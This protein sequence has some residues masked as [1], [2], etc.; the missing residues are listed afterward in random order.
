MWGMVLSMVGLCAGC[1]AEVGYDGEADGPLGDVA[2]K[3]TIAY[4]ND[5]QSNPEDRVVTVYDVFRFNVESA[6]ATDVS[7]VTDDMK[8]TLCLRDLSTGANIKCVSG[9]NT[10]AQAGSRITFSPD[11]FVFEVG[12]NSYVH[13]G[14]V[15]TGTRFGIYFRLETLDGI[16][17]SASKLYEYQWDN[18][19]HEYKCQNRP[20]A[21]TMSANESIS[22]DSQSAALVAWRMHWL[23]T[24]IEGRMPARTGSGN[25]G[26][27]W[28][29]VQ[30]I[31][32][33]WQTDY[34]TVGAQ[35]T[36]VSGDTDLYANFEATPTL[37][38]YTC[39]PASR[40]KTVEICNGNAGTRFSVRNYRTDQSAHYTLLLKP[41][42]IATI[43]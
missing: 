24:R 4:S 43:I 42:G 15:S 23:R 30:W 27:E 7:W 9:R 39:R 29:H 26:P 1:S 28:H 17:R 14:D 25:D 8:I 5:A 11:N 40:T 10:Q 13:P 21:G 35:L 20:S 32:P 36:V 41:G 6:V 16:D 12:R 38:S 3:A 19:I 22:I 34:A 2:E 33:D 31:A 37:T 18:T